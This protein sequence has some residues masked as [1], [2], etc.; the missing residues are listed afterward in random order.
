MPCNFHKPLWNSLCCVLLY[1]GLCFVYVCVFCFIACCDDRLYL[2]IELLIFS[3]SFWVFASVFMHS[4]FWSNRA[5][6]CIKHWYLVTLLISDRL[7]QHGESFESK[8]LMLWMLFDIAVAISSLL[9]WRG[10]IWI[11]VRKWNLS[12][13]HKRGLLILLLL[14]FIVGGIINGFAWA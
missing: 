3:I 12:S 7:S 6:V 5:P 4:I 9:E 11:Y 8:A 10:S 13:K 1:W 14:L 2:V